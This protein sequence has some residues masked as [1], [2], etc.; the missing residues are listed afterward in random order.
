L[1]RRRYQQPSIQ[2]TKSKRPE[3]FFRVRVDTLTS[4]DGVRALERPEKRYYVGFCDEISKQEAKHRR[5]AILGEVINK[6]QLLISSQVPFGDVLKVYQKD[7]LKLL[8]EDTTQEAQSSI[9]K[10]HIEPVFG[11]LRLC[12]IDALAVQRWLSSMDGAHSTRGARLRVLKTIW[13]KAEEW[14]FTQQRFPKA[15]YQLGPARELKGRELPPL[16]TIRRLLAALE[17]PWRAMAEIELFSGLRVS[18]VRGLQWPDVGQTTVV[19]KRRVSAKGGVDVTKNCKSRPVPVKPLEAVLGRVRGKDPVWVVP[20]DG[21]SYPNY[22]LKLAAAAKVAGVT[23]ARFGS[24]HLRA[25]YNTLLRSIG[26]DAHDRLALVGHADEKTNQLYI[27]SDSGDVQ[28][29][30]RL[31]LDVQSQIMGDTKGIQ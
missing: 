5:D 23:V 15:R 29:W 14:G 25:I 31:M 30:E 19:A 12:D 20:R 2:K 9:I 16:D 13:G 28:R 4:H 26:A 10:C 7:H 21:T 27:L 24:H 11:R 18:E 17:D 6:P 1:S 3:W 22:R 8:R